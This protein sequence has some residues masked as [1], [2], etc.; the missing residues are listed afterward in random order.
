MRT[1]ETLLSS[2]REKGAS[3]WLEQGQLRYRAP[4]TALSPNLLAELREKREEIITFLRYAEL[5]VAVGSGPIVPQPR[6][7]RLP[8]SHA[9]ER[10]W[11]LEQLDVGAAYNIPI[12]LRLEGPLDA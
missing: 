9:Q 7:K 1:V 10:L 6:P 2:V 4:K 12:A 5:L 8:L 3:L 11:L